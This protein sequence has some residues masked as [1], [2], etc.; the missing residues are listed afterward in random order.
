VHGVN[1]LR[2]RVTKTAIGAIVA[3]G[4]A[5]PVTLAFS[6]PAWAYGPSSSG[7]SSSSGVILPTSSG[8]SQTAAPAATSGSSGLAF[9]GAEVTGSLAVAAVALAGGGT[10]VLASRRRSRL[11]S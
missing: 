5:V 4:A 1:S 9:T 2:V 6:G 10:L 7:T 3:L 8:A 11:A